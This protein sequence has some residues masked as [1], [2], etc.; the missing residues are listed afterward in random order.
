MDKE[1]IKKQNI[2]FFYDNLGNFLRDKSLLYKYLVIHNKEVKKVFKEFPEA[3]KYAVDNLPKNEYVI[4][5]VLNKKEM[6]NFIF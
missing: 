4:Q 6:V 3:L 5:Q 1:S 2:D